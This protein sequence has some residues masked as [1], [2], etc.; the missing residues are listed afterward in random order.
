[1]VFSKVVEV[2]VM[3]GDAWV[4]VSVSMVVVVASGILVLMQ[5]QPAET[6][7]EL[8][9]LMVDL[10]VTVGPMAMAVEVCTTVVEVRTAT[11]RLTAA[12]GVTVTVMVTSGRFY[13]LNKVEGLYNA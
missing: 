5:L 6:M 13:V 1:V 9:A 11:A 12:A 4:V 2:A 8:K 3:V 7:A 10:K